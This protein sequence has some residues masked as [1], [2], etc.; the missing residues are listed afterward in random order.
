[1]ESFRP[2]EEATLYLQKS[3]ITMSETRIIFD[4]LI[5]LYPG[6]VEKY[7]SK[8]SNL[9]KFQNL[10]NAIVKCSTPLSDPL[11]DAEKLAME[12]FKEP[13]LST[14]SSSSF[15]NKG[16]YKNRQLTGGYVNLDTLKAN[17]STIERFFS[18]HK[19]LCWTVKNKSLLEKILFLRVNHIFWDKNDVNRVEA[20][21][22][23]EKVYPILDDEDLI[24]KYNKG[25]HLIIILN[26]QH[27]TYSN[28]V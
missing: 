10:E 13:A 6:S 1:M 25:K 22:I 27:I 14:Q 23:K 16:L 9:I 20:M 15:I 4:E 12:R 5:S 2:F 24:D 8:Y 7:L 3:D 11:I 21:E 26:F 28:A 18:L 17:N 19:N